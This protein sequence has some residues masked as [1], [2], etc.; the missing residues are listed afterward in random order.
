[1]IIKALRIA[2]FSLLGAVVVAIILG[3]N[4]RCI[5]VGKK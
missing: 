1:M 5:Q 2:F 4:N 3:P